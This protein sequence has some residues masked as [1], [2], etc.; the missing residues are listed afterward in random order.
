MVIP[1]CDSESPRT[2]RKKDR[3][4]LVIPVF[5]LLFQL[6]PPLLVWA[7]C[8]AAHGEP[9]YL[10]ESWEQPLSLLTLGFSAGLSIL[11]GSVSVYGLLSRGRPGIAVALI[12]VCCIPAFLGG[13]VYLHGLMVFLTF[14]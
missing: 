1:N 2:D 8:T 12:L 7:I 6:V 11:L 3:W 9:R 10:A 14:V 13:A 4:H 5:A